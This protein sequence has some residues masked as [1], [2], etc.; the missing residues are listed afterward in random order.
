[1]SPKHLK[2]PK[3][4][5]AAFASVLNDLSEEE[6]LQMEALAIGHAYLSEAQR[7]MDERVMLRKELAQKMK[8]SASFLTQLFRGDRPVSDYHKAQLARILK[9][10]WE[11]AAVAV[12]KSYAKPK[13]M[14]LAAEPVASYARTTKRRVK[15]KQC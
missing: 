11:V 5:K 3:A 6:L 13:A 10:K 7:I 4:V 9:I 12:R 2:D 14:S 15:V 1:M 8:V